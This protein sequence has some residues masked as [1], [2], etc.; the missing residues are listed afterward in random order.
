MNKLDRA[1]DIIDEDYYALVENKM[2][3]EDLS[4]IEKRYSEGYIAGVYKTLLEFNVLSEDELATIK[5]KVDEA[6]NGVYIG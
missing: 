2:D 1:L 3:N 6:V 5:E 4:D